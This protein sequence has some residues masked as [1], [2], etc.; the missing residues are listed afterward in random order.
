M[1]QHYHGSD[2][3]TECDNP[4]CAAAIRKENRAIRLHK[5]ARDLT[6]ERYT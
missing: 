6:E 4:Q 1:A 2:D 3:D 5:E